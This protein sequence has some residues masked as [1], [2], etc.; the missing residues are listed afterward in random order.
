MRFELKESKENKVTKEE[1]GREKKKGLEGER[2]VIWEFQSVDQR[3]N[4]EN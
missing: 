4:F 2:R 1:K 3:K